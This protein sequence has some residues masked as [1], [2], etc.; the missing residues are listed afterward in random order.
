[1]KKYVLIFKTSI[2]TILDRSNLIQKLYSVS[3]D[4]KFA[5]V[6]LDD[7]DFILRIESTRRNEDFISRFLSLEGHQVS[8]LA[9]FEKDEQERPLIRAS[10]Y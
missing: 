5:T 6:D 10:Y 4:V 2:R 8:F 9:A 7:E 3:K 1:M